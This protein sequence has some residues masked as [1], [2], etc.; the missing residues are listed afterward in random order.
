MS[1]SKIA[2]FYR[3]HPKDGEGTVFSLSVHTSRGGRGLVPGLDGGRG[4]AR[5]THPRS[6]LGGTLS[7]VLIGG[8]PIPDPGGGYPIQLI[9]GCPIPGLG[10]GVPIQLMRGTPI[11]GLDGGTPLGKD[12]MGY[13]PLAR[14]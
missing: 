6:G 11:P 4:G 8:Y 13:P 10:R 3:P 12:W 14:T 5:V 1:K 2:Y 7:Q 9:G